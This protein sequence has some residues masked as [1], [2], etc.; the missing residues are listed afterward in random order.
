M[1]KTA[2]NSP[3]W[4]L[5]QQL[6]E[7]KTKLLW[8]IVSWEQKTEKYAKQM[9]NE[10]CWEFMLWT[11]WMRYFLWSSFC[12]LALR[13]GKSKTGQKVIWNF[14]W[15][16]VTSRMIVGSFTLRFRP[17]QVLCWYCR[18]HPLIMK[19]VKLTSTNECRLWSLP[20]PT[21]L[22][23]QL[24]LLPLPRST[25]FDSSSW[26]FQSVGLFQYCLTNFVVS[27][28]WNHSWRLKFLAE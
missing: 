27:E 5:E 8:E 1:Q 16:V 4:S 7:W 19:V 9:L 24:L 10:L 18:T 13:D 12:S 21:K 26:K 15:N 6:V 25:Y 2:I 11:N 28:Q 22:F 23:N 20:Q 17:F 14:I 3:A